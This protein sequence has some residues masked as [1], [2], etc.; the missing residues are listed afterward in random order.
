MVE[1]IDNGR[2]AMTTWDDFEEKLKDAFL[3]H[4]KHD[5]A[6]RTINTIRQGK[7]TVQEFLIEF[8]MLATQCEFNNQALVMCLKNALNID[9]L[10]EIGWCSTYLL[11]YAEWH[12]AAI[13]ANHKTHE[14]QAAM[15]HSLAAR[16]L[17][18]KWFDAGNLHLSCPWVPC[19]ALNA[20]TSVP[21]QTSTS[22]P[23]PNAFLP[24]NI[25]APPDKFSHP[26]C[27]FSSLPCFNCGLNGHYAKSCP[28]PKSSNA[29]KKNRSML[30]RARAII[31][32]FEALPDK[33]REEIFRME[34]DDCE[35]SGDKD[36]VS[37]DE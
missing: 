27:D 5:E 35:E 6:A 8:N 30:E 9:L 32:E 28:K 21:K 15:S 3:N 14:T 2:Y 22:A 1:D 33:E 23:T 34:L 12:Q 10:A 26:R 25:S 37:C 24:A 36:F 20:N 17:S 11:T 4:Y 29:Q 7:K 19:T 18:F 16:H 13:I 31:E